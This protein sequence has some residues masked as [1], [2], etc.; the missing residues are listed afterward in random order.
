MRYSRLEGGYYPEKLGGCRPPFSSTPGS[1]RPALERI[2][3][4]TLRGLHVR[5]LRD[6]IPATSWR[7]GAL[8]QT[9]GIQMQDGKRNRTLVSYLLTVAGA[10]L[11][12]FAGGTVMGRLTVVIASTSRALPPIRPGSAT[13]NSSA[14]LGT[15][16]LVAAIEF[17]AILLGS[18]VGS[19]FMSWLVL[20]VGGYRRSGRTAVFQAIVYP[21]VVTVAGLVTVETTGLGL[22]GFENTL[23]ATITLAN[24]YWPNI[25]LLLMPPLVA[26]WLALRRTRRDRMA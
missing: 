20:S 3:F 2:M 19:A 5:R 13:T 11:G 1:N 26:R 22:F 15:V 4:E 18:W 25:P 17:T 21:L 6:D 9:R 23:A 16:L 8:V 7:V 10:L 12:G 24:V 14:D